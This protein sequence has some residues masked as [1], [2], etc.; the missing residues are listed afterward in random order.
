M[1]NNG[2]NLPFDEQYDHNLLDCRH[3]GNHANAS[4]A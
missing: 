1:F 2:L 4:L 3:E